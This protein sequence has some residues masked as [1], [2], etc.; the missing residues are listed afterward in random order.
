MR[1]ESKVKL[2]LLVLL[3]VSLFIPTSLAIDP[4]TNPSPTLRVEFEKDDAPLTDIYSILT[5]PAGSTIMIPPI[6]INRYTYDF[7]V[8]DYLF[9]GEYLFFQFSRPLL[10]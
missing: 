10:L 7:T 6:E 2:F 1:M 9:P 3:L 5:Y 8:T 4:T